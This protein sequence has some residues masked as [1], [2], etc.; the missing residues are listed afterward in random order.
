ML[1]FVVISHPN[2]E[3][4]RILLNISLTIILTMFILSFH[5]PKPKPPVT[6]S[7]VLKDIR[8]IVHPVYWH[9]MLEGYWRG[10]QKRKC[11]QCGS[12]EMRG[13]TNFDTRQMALP[14]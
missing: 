4:T 11:W 12:D 8:K 10:Y 5:W 6:L 3:V 13:I 1:T 14:P 7:D 9:G 2:L